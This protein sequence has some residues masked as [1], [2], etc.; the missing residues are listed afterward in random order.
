MSPLVQTKMAIIF[1]SLTAPRTTGA[2]AVA[3]CTLLAL[4]AC[5]HNP[6]AFT[7]DS[8]SI[9]SPHQRK[10]PENAEITCQ[11]ARRALLGDGYV[12]ESGDG[13]SIKGRKAYRSQSDRSTF[14][15][16]NVVCVPDQGGSTLYANGLLSTY[17]VK[18]SGGTASVGVT[19]LGSLSV[20][21]A[22]SAESMVKTA[23]ETITDREFYQRFFTSVNLVLL[24]L[25]ESGLATQAPAQDDGP[26]KKPPPDL[27]PDR[28]D[29][30][31]PPPAAAPEPLL[32]ATPALVAPAMPALPAPAPPDPA[33][34]APSAP[35]APAALE[36]QV[37]AMPDPPA[38]TM[39]APPASAP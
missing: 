38:T 2:L 26:V 6:A 39:P 27:T 19:A 15:E 12:V 7:K 21:F 13:E 37:P 5:G 34:P 10:F 11:G 30:R 8:F 3:T 4:G 33:V 28:P 9:N 16:M 23:D 35:A 20:P 32:P 36:S 25:P 22:Q 1:S 17:D 14:I 18:K 31:V 29:M 24:S